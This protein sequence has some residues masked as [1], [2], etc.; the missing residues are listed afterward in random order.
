MALAQLESVLS[1]CFE[2]V[3]TNRQPSSLLPVVR[4]R[5]LAAGVDSHDLVSGDAA[6]G[7]DVEDHEVAADVIEAFR[8]GAPTSG[9]ERRNACVFEGVV[10]MDVAV[11]RDVYAAF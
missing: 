2:C 3:E 11:E 7:V 8:D 1:G 6:L 9:D 4:S 5:S 10:R